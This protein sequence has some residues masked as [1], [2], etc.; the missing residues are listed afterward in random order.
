MD[1][2]F[3]VYQ[4]KSFYNAYIALEQLKVDDDPL[5]LFVPKLV[6][7]AFAVELTLKA[8][9]NK[10]G[11]KYDKEHNLK[12]LFDKLPSNIQVDFWKYLISKKPEYADK[13]KRENELIIMSNAFVKWRY[14]F[15]SDAPAFDET[16]LSAFANSAIYMMFHL[17]YNVF[18]GAPETVDN[19]EEIEK[20][21]EQNRKKYYESNIKYINS[22]NIK[23]KNET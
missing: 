17:G 3:L 7:G 4:A 9:L 16:F 12:V 2:D 10:Y 1:D 11:I 13:E 15:E 19:Y 22:E 18:F 21:L 14:C 20:K 8:I 5:L 23:S 6:N